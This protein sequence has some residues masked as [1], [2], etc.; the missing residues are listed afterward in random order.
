[1]QGWFRAKRNSNNVRGSNHTIT[2]KDG[3]KHLD[4]IQYPLMIKILGVGKE[5]NFSNLKRVTLNA[6]TLRL[7][8]R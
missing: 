7:R 5:R 3:E 8:R 6:L 1:M 2:S 4:K